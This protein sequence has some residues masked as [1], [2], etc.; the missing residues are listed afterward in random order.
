MFNKELEWQET[1]HILLLVDIPVLKS[2]V[3]LRMRWFYFLE[4]QQ[5]ALCLQKHNS[6]LFT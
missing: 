1:V 4:I 5:A 2:Q 3:C 6:R